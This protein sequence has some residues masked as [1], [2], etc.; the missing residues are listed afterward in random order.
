MALK[1]DPVLIQP[2]PPALSKP[3]GYRRRCSGRMVRFST[4]PNVVYLDA[5]EVEERPAEQD[6]PHGCED[7][8]PSSLA[9]HEFV[10]LLD[11]RREARREQ[12]EQRVA[13]RSASHSIA[14]SVP[15]GP[16]QLGSSSL[17]KRRRL[18]PVGSSTPG[19]VQLGGG[20]LNLA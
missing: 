14:S 19:P 9:S 4:S 11:E 18:P 16:L 3:G 20:L 8:S 6:S 5:I 12:R 17:A 2:V 15:L 10:R 13:M 7:N 1:V